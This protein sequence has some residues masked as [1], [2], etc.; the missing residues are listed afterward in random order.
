MIVQR[1]LMGKMISDGPAVRLVVQSLE[2]N[3]QVII[4][5][6]LSVRHHMLIGV[7]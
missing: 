3:Y 1:K 7:F 5:R 6:K 4:L 2:L